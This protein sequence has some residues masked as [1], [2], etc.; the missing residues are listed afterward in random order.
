MLAFFLLAAIGV[1][2]NFEGGSAGKVEQ[3]S[4]THLR[5]AVQGQSDQDGRNRQA[6]WY[7][8]RLDH[9]PRQEVTIDLVDVVGEYNYK[10]P[11][12][13]VTAGTRPV[14]SYDGVN[15]RHFR[16]DQ[17]SWDGRE[18]HLRVRFTP[19]QERMWIA[20]VPP[21]TNT[22]LTSLLDG[23]RGSPYL[24]RQ[25]AGTTVEGRDMPLLTITNPKLPENRKK[26]IWLMFRQHAWE[27]GTSW[28]CDGA[29]RF[30]LSDDELA[31]RTRDSVIVKVFPMADPDGVARGGVRF[32]RNGYDL[33][34]NWDMLDARTMPEIY[35]QHKAIMDWLDAG[36]RVD[37][38]LTQHNTETGEYLEAA[39]GDDAAAGAEDPLAQRLFRLLKESTTFNPTTELRP[40]GATTTPGKPGRMTVTQGLY[41]DRKIPALLMEQMIE[42]N[43]RL[44]HCPTVMDRREFGAGL[45]R[46]LARAVAGG[47]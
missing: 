47:D 36:H 20:H 39:S 28:V 45:V 6:D 18:P 37:L 1:T 12:Y 19:E 5:V 24:E 27:A 26:V 13:S 4:A 16:D 11:A 23:F 42:Y 33:N 30:L 8:F 40:A 14:Y 15:W 9:L 25:V 32:N 34:R 43:S 46:A 22:D 2:S 41:R 17:V 31:A 3:V 38:F 44:G 7:Y 35:S 21:Y 29:I 10:R